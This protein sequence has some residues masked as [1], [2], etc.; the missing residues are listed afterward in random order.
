MI[1]EL[2]DGVLFLPAIEKTQTFQLPDDLAALISFARKLAEEAKT[3]R[4][5]I[6]VEITVPNQN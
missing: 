3:T 2:E 5:N 1:R 6:L 4:K